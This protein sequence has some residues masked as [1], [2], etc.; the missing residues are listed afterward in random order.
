MFELTNVL[1][2]S[3]DPQVRRLGRAL[4][5]NPKST[6]AKMAKKRLMEQVKTILEHDENYVFEGRQPEQFTA[7]DWAK[8]LG[9]LGPFIK[10]LLLLLGGL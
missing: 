3:S 4:D 7:V 2:T 1:L 8:I 5:K 6:L 9:M 10:I